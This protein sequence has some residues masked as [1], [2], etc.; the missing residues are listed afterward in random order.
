MLIELKN[1]KRKEFNPVVAKVLIARGVGKEVKA[2]LQYQTR[3]M[4]AEIPSPAPQ[5]VSGQTV[6]LT[7]DQALSDAPYGYKA[8]GTPRK[9]PGRPVSDH[10]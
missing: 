1:G 7:E 10:E 6:K 4:T 3:M 8:D 5:H 9:R 2:G